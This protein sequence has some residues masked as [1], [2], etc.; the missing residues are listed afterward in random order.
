VTASASGLDPEISPENADIQSDR[1]ARARKLAPAA[2]RAVLAETTAGRWLGFIGES[3]VN[4]LQ[5][6]LA[7][8]ERF[9]SIVGSRQ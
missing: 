6:N 2:V 9:G 8:D 3:R 7:L 5:L 1:V 4:V